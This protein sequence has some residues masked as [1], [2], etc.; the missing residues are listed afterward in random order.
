MFDKKAFVVLASPF[1]LCIICVS[2]FVQ[3]NHGIET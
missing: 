1:D 3:G 2:I